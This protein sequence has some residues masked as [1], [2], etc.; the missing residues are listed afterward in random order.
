MTKKPTAL[1][2]RPDGA[3]TEVPAT[4]AG[5]DA[6]AW[7]VKGNQRVFM[8]IMVLLLGAIDAPRCAVDETPDGA[9]FVVTIAD[10][11]LRFGPLDGVNLTQAREAAANPMGFVRNALLADAHASLPRG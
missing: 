4:L 3:I 7:G 5:S 1:L 9:T 8:Q 10:H 2:V 6:R 11:Q